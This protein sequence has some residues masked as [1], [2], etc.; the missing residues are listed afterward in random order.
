MHIRELHLYSADL[1]AQRAFY[2]DVLNLPVI[3]ETDE[4]FSLGVGTS[5]LT[6]HVRP[7]LQANYHVAFNIPEN[8]LAAARAW[9][10]SRVPLIASNDGKTEFDFRSWNAHSIYFYDP[11]DNVMEFIARHAL[12][13]A[14]DTAFGA[15]SLLCISE[16]GMP[17]LNVQT[18]VGALRDEFDL[19][20]YD[21]EGSDT[22]T[23]LGDEHG[24]L[25]I[26][27]EGRNWYPDTGKAARFYEFT[28]QLEGG[29]EITE[30]SHGQ[31]G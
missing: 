7:G 10:S 26:V 12:P 8:Q 25:I 5:L 6:F 28:L 21:G 19:P 9:L 16:L 27:T 4:S 18:T 1:A 30:R 24:L 15:D 14:S 13:S 11:A 2:T 22:F 23:A 31:M 3:E 17:T 20:V 29:G